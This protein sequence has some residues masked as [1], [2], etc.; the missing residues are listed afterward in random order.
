MDRL[1]GVSRGRERR[2]THLQERTNRWACRSAKEKKEKGAEGGQST[3]RE[4]DLSGV[5]REGR[6]GTHGGLVGAGQDEKDLLLGSGHGWRCACG[7]ERGGYGFEVRVSVRGG[8]KGG[9]HTLLRR[10]F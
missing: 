5:G 3:E 2:G 9:Q 10:W 8:K 1:S 6:R 7:C 4:M